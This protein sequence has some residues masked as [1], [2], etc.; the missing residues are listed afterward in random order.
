MQNVLIVGLGAIGSIYAVK[1][2]E[3]DPD[4]VFVL[5]DD[6]RKAR[7]QREG[8]IFN[9]QRHDFNYL[10]PA[11]AHPR[12]DLILITTKS[13]SLDSA[14]DALTPFVHADT[15]ILSLLNGVSSPPVIAARI[16]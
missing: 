4:S 3:Y 10:T 5:V 16:G 13:H 1:L 15:V 8:I 6:T 9:G 7:Y 12:I 11:E 14:L 2:A